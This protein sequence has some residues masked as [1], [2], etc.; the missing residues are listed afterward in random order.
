[1]TVNSGRVVAP[2]LVGLRGNLSHLRVRTSIIAGLIVAA[3]GAAG[4]HALAQAPPPVPAPPTPPAPAPPAVA[5]A[6]PPE[7][8]RPPCNPAGG[9]ICLS[10]ERQEQLDKGHFQARGFVDLQFGDARIQADQLDMYESPKPDGSTARR[11]VAQGNVVFMRGEE[12]MAGE[13]LQMDLDTNYG[14]FEE[15]LGFVSPGILVE[16]KKIERLDSNTYRISD[17]KFTSCT[18]PNPRWSFT[19]TSATLDL[20]DKIRAHNVV[21]KV[22]DVPAFY[23]P[24]VIY[25]IEQDQRSTGLLFP[26]FGNSAQRGRNIGS[27]FFWAMGRSLDQT[28]YLD[29]YS[30]FGWGFGHEF[31][32]MRPSPSR[33]NFRTYLFRREDGGW[34]HD[35]KWDAVQ[36]LPGK[37]RAALRVQEVSTLDFRQQFNENLDYA[38]NRQRYSSASLQRSFG[39]LNVQLYAD[40]ADTFFDSE[41]TFDRRRHLPTLTVSGSPQKWRRTGLV[42][43]FDAKAENLVLGNQDRVDT[44]GRYDVYPRLSRPFALPWLQVTPEV[45]FRW[46][47]YGV[48]ELDG[49]LDGPARSRQYFEGLV[50]MRGPTFSKVFDTPGNFY[51]D[52]FKHTIGPEVTWRYRS[53]VEDFDVFPYFDGDDR[54]PG[55][56]EVVYGL[57]QRFYS[58]RRSAPGA[59][60][61]PYQFLDWKVSQTYYVNIAEG[62][63]AFDPNYSSNF[64]GVGG[65]PDHNSPI[66][67][68]LRFTPTPGVRTNFTLEYDINFNEVRRL[69]LDTSADYRRG[70]YQLGWSKGLQRRRRD[71]VATPYS[72]VRGSARLQLVPGKLTLAGSADYNLEKKDLVQ[73][74]GRL[75]YDA[76]CCG[77]LVEVIQSDYNIKDDLVFRFSIE[78][79]NV[80]AIGNFMGQ[81]AGGGYR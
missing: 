7:Q 81:D 66:L 32:Y 21:F 35:L 50:D 40:S 38:T 33:G 76:Q 61:V 29:H 1:L 62:Q 34:D 31:R 26:H 72:T 14:V 16:G 46:T 37:V 49:T 71:D 79:A 27:G 64:F 47:G 23:L 63:N 65:V 80:G 36:V 24:Y 25:P 69:S 18:Q 11:I 42:G 55:T 58:K 60:P 68:R 77:F 54:I 12:R 41:E 3:M 6:A 5:P 28:F 20:D 19:A 22:K 44:Y 13:R 51:S 70:G 78:L 15:A 10:A 48:S 39:N 45:Q 4:Q 2:G 73:S 74:S 53:K 59:K 8:P 43:A 30:E 67:S 9:D 52:R 17:G 56:H 57:A 75:R